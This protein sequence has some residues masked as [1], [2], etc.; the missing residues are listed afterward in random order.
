[1]CNP[2]IGEHHTAVSWYI[3]ADQ[4]YTSVLL[5]CHFLPLSHYVHL[6]SLIHTKVITFHRHTSESNQTMLSFSFDCINVILTH[7][8]RGLFKMS[9]TCTNMITWQCTPVRF[10]FH[11]TSACSDIVQ[12]LVSVLPWDQD[13]TKTEEKGEKKKS[14]SVS[15]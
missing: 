4:L 10:L 2:Y 7:H 15:R 1:M 11:S 6:L 9:Q 13:S 12:M 3:Q 5:H 14:A 8:I